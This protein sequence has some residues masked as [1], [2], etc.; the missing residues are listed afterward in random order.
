MAVN[1]KFPQQTQWIFN[2]FKSEHF[3]YPSMF[4]QTLSLDVPDIFQI[5]SLNIY[6]IVQAPFLKY[7][8]ILLTLH[9]KGIVR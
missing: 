6:K 3:Y 9:I 2:F 8:H 4:F 7:F 5:P 1:K